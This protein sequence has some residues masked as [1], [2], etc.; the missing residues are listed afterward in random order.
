M[1]SVKTEIEKVEEGRNPLELRL[2]VAVGFI[3][4]IIAVFTVINQRAAPDSTVNSEVTY[5][6]SPPL[7]IIYAPRYPHHLFAPR[8]ESQ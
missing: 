1:K 3:T 4:S 5:T 8:I 2:K 6:L 7:P